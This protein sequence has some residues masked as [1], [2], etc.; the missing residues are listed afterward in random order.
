MKFSYFLLSAAAVVVVQSC[1]LAVAVLLAKVVS[2]VRQKDSIAS[3][4]H[5]LTLWMKTTNS[6]QVQS[7]QMISLPVHHRRHHS[8]ENRQLLVQSLYPITVKLQQH[9]LV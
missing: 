3:M 6:R 5:Q 7:A 1:S 9:Q 2:S 4:R 8:T